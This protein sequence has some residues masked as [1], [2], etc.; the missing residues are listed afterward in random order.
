M[1]AS[2]HWAKTAAEAAAATVPREDPI[3]THNFLR[4]GGA[5]ADADAVR[6]NREAEEVAAVVPWSHSRVEAGDQGAVSFELQNRR[7]QELVSKRDRVEGLYNAAISERQTQADRMQQLQADVKA[8]T[9][10]LEGLG[11][12][13]KAFRDTLAD[14]PGYLAS[15]TDMS[16]S[17]RRMTESRQIAQRVD[18]MKAQ[19]KR[20][21]QAHG[22]AEQQTK[23]RA[24]A[25]AVL[26]EQV[27]VAKGSMAATTQEAHVLPMVVGQAL[28]VALS[29]GMN[30]PLRIDGEEDGV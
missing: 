11:A 5:E 2:Q 12:E 26:R 6:R 9:A 13:E 4:D 10:R 15:V 23:Q 16:A 3:P 14:D 21:H 17:H 24:K 7:W 28:P 29:T 8:A 18:T 27:S 22:V 20:A 30:A 1:T 25:L 19:L